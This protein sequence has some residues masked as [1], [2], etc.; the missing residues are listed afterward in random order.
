MTESF[1]KLCL[2][3]TAWSPLWEEYVEIRKVVR[4]EH[5]RPIILAC[6]PSVDR[7]CLFRAEELTNYVL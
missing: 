4:D 3:R 7:V 1:E 2:Y 5:D 6:V